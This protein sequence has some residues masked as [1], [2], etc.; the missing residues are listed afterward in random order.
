MS[1]FENIVFGPLG[2]PYCNYFYFLSVMGYIFMILS[3]LSLLYIGATTKNTDSKFY[4]A[5]V[6][7][8]LAYGIFYFQNRLLYSMCVGSLKEGMNPETNMIG[9]KYANANW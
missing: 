4:M 3:L 2:K 9:T 5:G 7:V 1:D 8:I 6:T